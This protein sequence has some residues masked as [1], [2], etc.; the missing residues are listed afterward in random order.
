MERVLLN[1]NRPDAMTSKVMHQVILN[2]ISFE[3]PD[4]IWQVID[5]AFAHYWNEEI[6]FGNCAD[7]FSAVKSIDNRLKE[8]GIIFSVEKIVEILNA[9]FEWIEQVPGAILDD[10]L[11]VIPHPFKDDE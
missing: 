4:H 2:K 11:I 3:L 1:P 10:D 8:K 5:N 9:M 6:G 7:M